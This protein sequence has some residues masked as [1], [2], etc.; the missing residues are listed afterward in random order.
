MKLFGEF[1]DDTEIAEY[2]DIQEQSVPMWLRRHGLQ[3]ALL[4]DAQLVREGKARSKGRGARSDLEQARD[5]QEQLD[6]QAAKKLTEE[7]LWK[8]SR[9]TR[10]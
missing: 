5:Q 1:W 2:L 9:S 6:Q 7:E 8:S 3:R 10:T 4:M